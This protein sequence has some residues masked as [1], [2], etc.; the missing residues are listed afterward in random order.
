[1]CGIAGI[2]DLYQQRPVDRTVL[3]S[4]TRALEHRGPDDE[5]YFQL[6]GIGLGHR[7]LSIIDLSGG[8]QPLFNEDETVCVVFNGE[9]YNFMELASELTAKGHRFRTRCDT[10]AIVH[11]WEEWGPRCVERFRGMFAFALFDRNTQTLF[12][13]RDRLGIKPLYYS[14]LDGGTVVFGSELKALLRHPDLSREIDPFAVEDFFAFGY[15]P[16][17]RSIYRSVSKL[18]PGHTL[19]LRRGQAEEGDRKSVV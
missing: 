12:L 13:A 2:F 10:E 18:P 5:G 6:P 17:P 16:D 15:I 7:R 1:M 4:M 9:I 14:M 11:A 19:T 8:H 3:Q